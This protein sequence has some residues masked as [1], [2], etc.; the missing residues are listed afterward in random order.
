MAPFVP[1]H[2][3]TVAELQDQMQ[4]T[5]AQVEFH[6]RFLGM[7]RIAVAPEHSVPDLLAAAGEAALAGSDRTK[8]RYLLHAHTM[9]HAVPDSAELLAR[10]RNGLGLTH[11]RSFAL[12]H[13]NCAA[14]LYML[15]LAASLLRAEHPSGTALLLSGEKVL[16]PL[17]RRNAGPT[18]L[19]EAAAGL[20]VAG[21]GPGHEVL[22][23]AYR[24]LG[25]FHDVFGMTDGT[26]RRYE[27][28]YIPTIAAVAEEAAER[29]GTAPERVALIL[30]HNV[31]RLFLRQFGKAL[32]VPD[33]RV[34]TDNVS[35]LGHCFCA[36]PFIN[37]SS[38][39][40]AGSLRAGDLAL[41]VS[42]G[43]G[44][45]FSAAVLRVGEEAGTSMDGASGT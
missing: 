8:V 34:F 42:A 12:S 28:A 1:R 18:L 43:L 30:P 20:L 9:Q 21:E 41:L 10:L 6:R 44:A 24:V 17:V 11:A 39:L 26:R 3:L 15:R 37:L 29:A 14:G 19:G 45:T 2:R 36:D 31:N 38:A 22:S 4:L 7:R 32:G 33:E 13:Q 40:T 35:E 16:S 27:K 5:D 23:V 25:G